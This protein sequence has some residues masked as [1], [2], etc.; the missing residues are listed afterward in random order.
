MNNTT[1]AEFGGLSMTTLQIDIDS[2]TKKAADSLFDAIGIDTATAVKMFISA[3]IDARGMPFATRKTHG[4]IEVNDGYG[5]YI[6]EYGHLHDYS[7]LKGKLEESL[8]ETE[9]PFNSVDDLFK[10]LDDES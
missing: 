8:N 1:Q 2:T 6:C 7:K 4:V 9:G 5:S 3:A 10:S